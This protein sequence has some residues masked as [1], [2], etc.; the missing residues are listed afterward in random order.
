MRDYYN[1]RQSYGQHRVDHGLRSHPTV[2]EWLHI[3]HKKY[4]T[5]RKD[6]VLNYEIE[7]GNWISGDMHWDKVYKTKYEP[8]T[9]CILIKGFP[10]Y[11]FPDYF[12]VNEAQLEFMLHRIRYNKATIYYNHRSVVKIVLCRTKDHPLEV[13]E[14]IKK[15]VGSK[16]KFD[17]SCNILTPHTPREWKPGDKKCPKKE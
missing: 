3:L 11:G 13:K 5:L 15:Q 2:L 14:I 7:I 1:I 10:R 12:K 9:Q 16:D 4:E 6:E 8:T 17:D